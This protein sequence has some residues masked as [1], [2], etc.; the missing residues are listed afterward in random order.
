MITK[1]K[2]LQM[3]RNE[4]LENKDE[5]LDYLR[6]K[7]ELVKIL[8][9]RNKELG[10]IKNENVKKALLKIRKR[11]INQILMDIRDVKMILP[12]EV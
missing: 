2:I 3:K 4:L 12:Y 1:S 7:Y 5:I 10:E 6:K 9:D 11:K 8:E